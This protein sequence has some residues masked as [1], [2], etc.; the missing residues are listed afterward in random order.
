MT[1][2]LLLG[3]FAV[4]TVLVI[5]ALVGLL[6]GAF[7]RLLLFPLFLINWFS[8]ALVMVVVGPI[9][10][11]V[12]LVLMLVFGLVI[13]VPLIP[14]LVVVTVLWLLVRSTRRPAI[15]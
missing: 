12:G 9:L 6:V 5:M 15:V 2:L 13:A 11:I 4:T 3:V 14:L 7:V 10:A 1:V 8:P